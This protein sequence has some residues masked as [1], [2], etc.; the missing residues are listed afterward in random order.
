ML[1]L[2][3]GRYERERER[4]K[5]KE[6]VPEKVVALMTV[7]SFGMKRHRERAPRELRI[8][9]GLRGKLIVKLRSPVT[10]RL[11]VNRNLIVVVKWT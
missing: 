10:E 1:E 8:A 4:E 6:T 2:I 3:E 5:R 7:G 11:D 9:G